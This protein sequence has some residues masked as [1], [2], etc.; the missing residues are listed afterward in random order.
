MQYVTYWETAPGRTMPAYVALS[1]VSLERVLGG[2]LLLLTPDNAPDYIGQA[3]LEKDWQFSGLEFDGCPVIT[4]IVAKSDFIRMAYV[5]H[6]GGIWLDA[7]SIMFGDLRPG[8]FPDMFDDHLHWYSEVL[9]GAA[10]GHPLLGDAI[11]ACLSQPYQEWGN[12]GGIR[13][14]IADRHDMVSAISGHAL[15]PGYSPFYCF[16]TCEVM[17]DRRLRPSEFLVNP[18]LRL[19]K[20]Y[21]MYFG[22]SPLALLSVEELLGS[23]TLLAHLFLHL[24]PNPRFWIERSRDLDCL[25]RTAA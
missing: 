17:F 14:L 10:P 13:D 2:D 4:S 7:D 16:N 22:R 12:P 15:D 3:Y 21:N 9:F 23:G 8:I 1:L 18:D 19:L 20:L 5:Y 24:E 11:A 25:L 6:H